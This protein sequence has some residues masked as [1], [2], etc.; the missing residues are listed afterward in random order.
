MSQRKLPDA[1][2]IS[3]AGKAKYLLKHVAEN[4][5]DVADSA[6]ALL[7][8]CE[9]VGIARPPDVPEDQWREYAREVAGEGW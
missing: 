4:H 9:A 7:G 1:A 5:P 3:P 8:R 6:P 2:N